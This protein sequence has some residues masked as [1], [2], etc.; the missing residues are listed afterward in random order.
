M[1]ERGRRRAAE[2]CWKEGKEAVIFNTCV[3]LFQL[4]MALPGLQVGGR[5]ERGGPICVAVRAV[6]HAAQ[7]HPPLP[8]AP[9]PP[10]PLPPTVDSAAL[11]ALDIDGDS[12]RYDLTIDLS[13]WNSNRLL[14][15]R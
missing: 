9:L 10:G 2:E 1:S 11:T 8:L 6:L 15:N 3:P 12:L 7:L 13:F 4:H 5:R 14:S